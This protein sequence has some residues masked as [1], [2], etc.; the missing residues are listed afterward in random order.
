MDAFLA[1][2]PRRLALIAA[3]AAG[4][5]SGP[6]RTAAAE[7]GGSAA[8]LGAAELADL[9]ASLERALVDGVGD[10]G[11]LLAATREEAEAVRGVLSDARAAGWPPE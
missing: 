6:G 5:E 3:S 1:E 4:G 10:A 2:L 8:A 7:L 9:A 11:A